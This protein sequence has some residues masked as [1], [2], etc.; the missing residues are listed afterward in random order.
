[1]FAKLP[2]STR[3]CQVLK[4]AIDR[5]I[6]KASSWG[7][8]SCLELSFV[9][10]M[11]GLSTL[12]ALG[13]RPEIWTLYTI[14]KYVFLAF[15][16]DPAIVLPPTITLISLSVA[17]GF[18]SARRLCSGSFGGFSPFLTNRYNFPC[19]MRASICC[20]R[21]QHLELSCSWSWWKRQYLFQCLLLGLPFSLSG[22]VSAVSSLSYIRT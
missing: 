9:K 17:L 2:L 12:I 3:T 14:C 6:T 13:G 15:L 5:L 10:L 4:F 21:L 20:L 1:M 22:H 16:D 18:S 19:L 11:T 7:W 8:C